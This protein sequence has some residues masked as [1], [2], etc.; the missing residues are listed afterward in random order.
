MRDSITEGGHV[1]TLSL[2]GQRFGFKWIIIC[3]R[4]SVC[5]DLLNWF[6]DVEHCFNC[7]HADW[8]FLSSLQLLLLAISSL[9]AYMNSYITLTVLS[10]VFECYCAVM[11]SRHMVHKRIHRPCLPHST[12]QGLFLFSVHHVSHS[13]VSSSVGKPERGSWW[14]HFLLLESLVFVLIHC[15]SLELRTP[16]FPTQNSYTPKNISHSVLE[17]FFNLTT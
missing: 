4:C 1:R 17:S 14:N 13:L 5:S 2:Q 9:T 12:L 7:V 10:W 16:Q 3:W 11:T 6:G 8:R 15:S